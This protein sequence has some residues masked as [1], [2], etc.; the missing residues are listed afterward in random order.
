MATVFLGGAAWAGPIV[1][2]IDGTQQSTTYNS[3]EAMTLDLGG[4][5]VSLRG[6]TQRFS[7]LSDS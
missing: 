1:V 6:I 3:G 2:E 5:V 4:G 7:R